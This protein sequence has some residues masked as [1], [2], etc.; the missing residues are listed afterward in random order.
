MLSELIFYGLV[1]GT[2]FYAFYKWATKNRE[3]FV[4]RNLKHLNPNFLIG[5]TTGLFLKQYT[6]SNFLDKLYYSY[7]KEKYI[8][9]I[10]F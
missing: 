5:N 1:G 2:L 7:P 8:Q 6:P 10:A 4:K 3:Y 9:F